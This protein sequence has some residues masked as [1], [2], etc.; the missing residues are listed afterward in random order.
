MVKLIFLEEFGK[1]FVP[2]RFRPYLRAH[3]LKANI[4][5]IPFRLFGGLFYAALLITFVAYFYKVFPFLQGG[6]APKVF[7]YTLLTWTA[8]PLVL[9]LVFGG[10][11]YFYLDLIIFN[12]TKRM[13]EVLPDFLRLVSENLKGGMPFERAM[14]SAI[15]PEFDILSSEVR[16]AAK[17]V[18]TGEDI[19]AALT[20][21]T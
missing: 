17:R 10:A 14:W 11:I 8:L 6:A 20:E 13:E 1:A 9:A 5:E 16:L 19:G 3:F 15:K 7:L 12:R 2:K 18:M 4:E 21:F